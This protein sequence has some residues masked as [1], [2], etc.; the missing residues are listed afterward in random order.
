MMAFFAS[1]CIKEVAILT[2]KAE[3]G[4]WVVAILMIAA[5][6][7]GLIACYFYFWKKRAS[8]VCYYVIEAV[9]AL[10]IVRTLYTVATTAVYAAKYTSA[11][12]A[13]NAVLMICVYVLFGYQTYV[14]NKRR[15]MADSK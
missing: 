13:V 2:T 6:L 4:S 5:S 15:K 14:L 9:S 10:G 12:N 7:A 11:D 3:V 8:K 1:N